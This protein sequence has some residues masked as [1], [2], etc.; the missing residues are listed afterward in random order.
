MTNLERRANAYRAYYEHLPLRRRSRPSGPDMLL[1]RGFDF[2]RLASFSVLDTR[3]YR[4]D[5]P[6]ND[7]FM[8]EPCPEVDDPRATMTGPE[9]ER[10]LL[11]RM[12]RSKARWNVVAQQTIMAPFDYLVGEG[13]IY[14]LDQWDGYPAARERVL[15]FI[16]RERPSNPV[17]LSGDWHSNWVNDL[18]RTGEVVATEFV[19]TSISSGIGWDDAVR[20]GL[21]EN[22]HVRFYNGDYRGYVVC[23]VTPERWISDLRI[24]TNPRDSASPAY[25]LASFEVA[26]G[27]PGAR[28]RP[29]SSDGATG[30]VTDVGTGEPLPN[31]AVEARD[32]DG[33]V[34]DGGRTDADGAYL[35]FVQPGTYELVA[36][37]VG[38]QTATTTAEVVGGRETRADLALTAVTVAAGTGRVVPGPRSQAG[39]QDIVIE[40]VLLA[41]AIAV[42]FEDGQ[43][44]G[45]TKGKPVDI[46]MRGGGDQ[47]DWINLPYASAVQPTGT[48]SWQQ[49]TVVNDEVA[50][51]EVTDER[52]VVRTTGR[53]TDFDGLSA[54]TTYTVRRDER[55]ITAETV[56]ENRA[57]TAR[58]VWVGDAMDHDGAGQSS[59]VPGH[60]TITTPYSSPRAF[61]PVEPWVGMTGTDRQTFGLIYEDD[62]ADADAYGT[63]NYILSRI[64]VVIPAGEAYT[65]R[66]RI[67]AADG[68]TGPDPFAVLAAI[69]RAGR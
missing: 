46:A 51:I 65:L 26:D 6:C 45:A 38:Y 27:R 56:Y 40:N 2:G 66:R 30:R 68:G 42:D 21:A 44:P 15:G 24:V 55:W 50:V 43:L 19:G 41:M 31:V 1:Y 20:Q 59:G 32:G 28:R 7:R 64:P 29:G 63:G 37:G 53:S 48:A 61:E 60:G 8:S 39:T 25:T 16:A 54:V 10:W 36:M 14:N 13:E 9:Q 12:G 4:S 3:Q 17:V 11:E 62:P 5:Q 69:Y 33:R 35:L 47:M 22:A 52:A 67:V 34:A 23:D 57:S 18:E 58:S 49:L